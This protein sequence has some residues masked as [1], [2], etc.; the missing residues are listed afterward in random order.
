MRSLCGT[1][2]G[3]RYHVLELIGEGGMG[4]VFVAEHV[5]L[6]RRMAIKVL[7]EELSA[8]PANVQRF[9]QEAQAAS[10]IDHP[11]VVDVVDFGRTPE[12]VVY[13][14]MEYLEGE[15]LT[16]MMHRH[17]AL[18]WPSAQAII[19]QVVRGL[20]AAHAKGVVYRDLKPANVYLTRNPDGSLLVKLLDFG[21]AKHTGLEQRPRTKPNSVFGT[22]RYM[23]PEQAA[24]KDVDARSDIY[25]TGVVLY[26]MLTARAPFESDNYMEVVRCH[27]NDPIP[28]PRDVAPKAMIPDFVE[29]LVMRALEKSPDARYPNMTEFEAAILGA[30]IEATMASTT[31]VADEFDSVDRTFI[32]DAERGRL[33]R[34]AAS[35]A[36]RVAAPDQVD[37]TMIMQA[38]TGPPP[39]NPTAAAAAAG[40]VVMP[41]S[42]GPSLRK[43]TLIATSSPLAATPRTPSAPPRAGGSAHLSGS[44]MISTPNGGPDPVPPPMQD[45]QP[46]FGHSTPAAP[47]P[48]FQSA[49]EV[50]PGDG[51]FFAPTTASGG[52]GLGGGRAAPVLPAGASHA[53][54]SPSAHQ[55][56]PP[57]NWSSG[58]AANPATGAHN[59]RPEQSP[60]EEFALRVPRRAP[61]RNITVILI[62]VV[63]VLAVGIGVATWAVF[64]NDG[65]PVEDDV[66]PTVV[67]DQPRPITLGGAK[68][69]PSLTPL[70][71]DRDPQPP[72]PGGG[73]PPPPRVDDSPAKPPTP[74]PERVD[75]R[76]ARPQPEPREVEP[77]PEPKVTRR[78]RPRNP[79]PSKPRRPRSGGG[80]SVRKGFNRAK[81]A[82]QDC[83][84]SRGAI[85]GTKFRVTFDV[86]GGKAT[87]IRVQSPHSATSLGKCVAKVVQEKARFGGGDATDQQQTV[88]F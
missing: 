37:A 16:A 53:T 31:L 80:S 52:G 85:E 3:E 44:T 21:I 18:P 67:A 66:Y 28:R 33:A 38:P 9:L 86:R 48:E 84:K 62:A 41:V 30:S 42:A 71:D 22:A 6:K 36:G 24:G 23:S 1:V 61:S 34:E 8:E 35:Q 70:Q 10:A 54:G 11:N 4:H 39:G 15:E 56:L 17:G 60:T 50:R 27:V 51:A 46:V 45:Q 19:L 57:V 68:K 26:E 14:V 72:G 20:A 83:G 87:N 73:P 7:R 58:A 49:P 59:T 43:K 32:W 65:D 78:P 79:G 63:A 82:I 74:T 47:E 55:T 2:L 88:S 5:T 13:F 25:A 12:G 64:F 75:P 76:A 77:D 29:D 40:G 69:E 81:K